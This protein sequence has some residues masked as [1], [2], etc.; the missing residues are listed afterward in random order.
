MLDIKF[1]REN[2]ELVEKKSA[3]K[4]VKVD[5]KKLLEVDK[6]RLELIQKVDELRAKRNQIADQMKGGKPEPSLVEQGKQIKVELVEQES[7]LDQAKA[8]FDE[9]LN[10]I[11]NL[12]ADDVPVGGEDKNKVIKTVGDNT[13]KDGLTDHLTWLEQRDLVDFERGAKVAGAKFFY[14]KGDLARLEIALTQFAM[15]EVAKH[16]FTPMIVPNL[17]NSRAIKGTGFAPKGEEK[18]IYSV[19][20]EDLNLIA[21]SEIPLTAYH[22]DEIIDIERLP[23]CYVGYSPCYRVEAGAYGKHSKGLFRVHQFYKVE[24]YVFCAP[25]QSEQWHQKILEIEES[26]MTKLGIA[27]QV[28]NIASGDLGAPAYKKYDIE[29][30]SPLDGSYREITSCS[31]VTEYQARRMNIRYRDKDGQTKFV[32][33]LNGTAMVTSRAPIAIIENHQQSDGHVLIPEAL[34]KYMNG[35]EK[36]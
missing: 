5:V 17:V 6:I 28:V 31:N 14:S 1:I 8:E 18:Q 13:K 3:E 25:D 33:T 9:S 7:L 29:Y 35:E 34:K 15:D 21:T 32:H 19:E 24:M 22:A 16:G 30:F 4:N 36:I 2:P 10:D 11:P 23:I 27:Y 20:G 12:H 26:I